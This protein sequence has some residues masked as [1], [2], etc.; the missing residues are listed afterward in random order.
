MPPGERMSH[1]PIHHITVDVEE[2]FHSTLLVERV[3]FHQWDAFPRRASRVVP[4]ILEQFAAAGTRAT[5]FVLG[6]TAERDPE[7]VREI[8]EA[9]HEVAAHSWIHRRVDRITPEEFRDAVRR[10]KAL[11]ED[12]TGERV[13]GYRAPSFSIGRGQEW[14]FDVLLEE[15]YEYDSSLFPI[16]AGPGYGYRGGARDP[17]WLDRP[18]GRLGEVPLLT[19]QVAGRSWPAGGGGYLRLLPFQLVTGA[20]RQAEKR[21]VPGTLYIHPWDIDPEL[22]PPPGLPHLL[23]LRLFGGAKR[24]RNRLARLIRA[25]PSRALEDTLQELA[26]TETEKDPAS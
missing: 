24:A 10:S 26:R 7:M 21:Q 23:H 8:S 15:G 3:P 14:A 6:W 1:G 5:F 11:L 19:L 16:H 9:G 25:F 4:W 17:H 22:D 13:L 12:I 20:L 18:E 2:F